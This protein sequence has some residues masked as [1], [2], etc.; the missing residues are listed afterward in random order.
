MEAFANVLRV[1]WMVFWW[2]VW[3]G[4][5]MV[6]GTVRSLVDASDVWS[7]C[8]WVNAAGSVIYLQKCEEENK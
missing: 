3:L 7:E 6:Y 4:Y 5:E 2:V 8:V 1:P